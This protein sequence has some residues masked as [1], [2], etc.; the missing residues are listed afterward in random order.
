MTA[1]SDT[2]ALAIAI[3]GV[4]KIARDQHIPALA[5]DPRFQ[6]AATASRSGGVQGVETFETLGALLA[7][8]PDI[9]AVSL[10]MPPVPRF[11]A[12]REAIAAG[13]H[14]MLEKPPGASLAEVFRLE[15]L[16]RQ[17]GVTL[18][19]SWHSRAAAGVAPAREWLAGRRPKRIRIDWKEDVRKWHPGQAWIWEPGGLGVFDPGINALSILTEICPVPLHLT[20]STLTFPENRA[21]P[22]AAD[23]T[24]TDGDGL[25]ATAGF[26]WRQEGGDIWQMEIDTDAGQL[27]LLDGGA[28][29]F[30][31]GQETTLDDTGEYPTL[32]RQF[33]QLIAEGRSDVDA[34]PLIHVADAFM[35]GR[36][37]RGDP[38]HD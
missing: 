15:A 35:L 26:D 1:S 16:A 28:R 37:L 20:A 9:P 2:N 5:R 25:D 13:R 23:L 38:F 36:H 7:A 33:G 21:T 4:G 34:A 3:V 31:D 17:A 24:F 19:A 30:I 29:L 8:R 27:R 6:L 14:V 10:C 11:A 18:F 32:Y 22:I 12:A